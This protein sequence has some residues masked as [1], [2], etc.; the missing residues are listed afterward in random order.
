MRGLCCFRK[1]NHK[2][3]GSLLSKE[4]K[5]HNSGQGEEVAEGDYETHKISTIKAGTL[6]K[7]VENLLTAFGDNDFTYISIFLS[8]F[9]AFVSTKEEL[10]L[11]DRYGNLETSSC[12]E[13]GT[14]ASI[15]RAWL[16]QCSEDFREPPDYPWLMKLLDY[17]KRNIPGS[18][19]KKRAQNLLDQFQNQEVENDDG[20][21]SDVSLY[22]CAEGCNLHLA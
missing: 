3:F 8:A 21:S 16:D 14:I 7:L 19:L 17:L 10:E 15:L 4:I 11:L 9:R 18:D 13:D 5:E 20:S 12:E 2:R 6:E 22:N 1:A